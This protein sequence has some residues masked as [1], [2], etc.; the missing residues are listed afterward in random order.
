MK[1]LISL[2]LIA[3]TAEEAQMIVVKA[4]RELNSAG[5][6]GDYHFEI[7]TPD[8]LVTEKCVLMGGKVIA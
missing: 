6:V 3:D 2:D 8:G 1:A 7:E 5:L 4:C